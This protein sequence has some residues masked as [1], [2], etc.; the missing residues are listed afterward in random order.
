MAKKNLH[1]PRRTHEHIIASQS[2]DYVEK[3]F[4]D[5]GHTAT[6]VPLDY[7]TDLLVE[8]FDKNGFAE[9]GF[10][11]LQLRARS[12][13][14]Y[15]K[16]GTYISFDVAAKHIR[17]WLDEDYPFFLILYDPQKVVAYYSISLR[18]RRRNQRQ[19]RSG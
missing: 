9:N 17:L 12:N 6:P 11:R 5:R 10:I 16:D 15:S 18:P 4:I 2:Q 8:T 3:F 7:G 14:K 1:K 19:Q 13:L